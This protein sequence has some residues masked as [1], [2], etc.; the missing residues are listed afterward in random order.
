MLRSDLGPTDTTLGGR[1]LKIHQLPGALL[2]EAHR[3]RAPGVLTGAEISREVLIDGFSLKLALG[4]TQQAN[5]A[6]AIECLLGYLRATDF[7]HR[8]IDV[9]MNGRYVR[10]TAWSDH[11]RP[12]HDQRYTRAAFIQAAFA[13]AQRCIVSDVLRAFQPSR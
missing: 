6:L 11:A 3:R 8:W 10:L 5:Q 2:N 1:L 13:T 7:K 12:T 4:G 9:D